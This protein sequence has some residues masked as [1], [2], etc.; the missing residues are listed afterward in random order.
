MAAPDYWSFGPCFQFLMRRLEG[1]DFENV[2]NDHGGATRCGVIQA[3][4]DIFRKAWKQPLQ[5]VALITEAEAGKIYLAG[6]WTPSRCEELARPIRFPLFQ[7]CVNHGVGG[8]ISSLQHVLGVTMDGALG[9]ETLDATTHWDPFILAA[10]LLREQREW[11]ENRVKRDPTQ[12]AFLK[13]DWLPRI[14][15]TAEFIGVDAVTLG[16]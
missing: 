9:N 13:S 14:R 12:L 6:Y 10:K 16:A 7:W 15:Q 8:G 3:T 5:S 2:K 1:V 4:Y 11:Y